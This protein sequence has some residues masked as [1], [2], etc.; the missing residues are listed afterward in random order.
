M[1]SKA[2]LESEIN[3]NDIIHVGAAGEPFQFC[4]QGYMS[5]YRA[6]RAFG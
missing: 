5:V 4:K 2:A 6:S 1:L 3:I